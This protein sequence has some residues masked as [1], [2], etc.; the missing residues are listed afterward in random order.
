MPVDTNIIIFSVA[1]PLTPEKVLQE[2]ANNDIRAIKFGPKEIRMVT[3]LDFTDDMLNRTVE[4]IKK[5]R[6]N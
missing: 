3:H 4:V 5:L 1:N 6:I 2:F